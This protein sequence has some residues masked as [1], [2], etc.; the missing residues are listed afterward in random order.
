MKISS[1]FALMLL[2]ASLGCAARPSDSTTDMTCV[3]R[4][5]LPSYPSIA[6][7]ARVEA[8]VSAAVLLSQDGK[9]EKVSM[10][11][12]SGMEYAAKLFY[13]AVEKA[14]KASAFLPSCGGKTVHLAFDFPF[15]TRSE[16]GE[17]VQTVRFKNPNRF[18][19]ALTP[20]PSRWYTVQQ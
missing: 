14:M 18:E 17:T 2:G 4:L 6:D 13:P 16:T 10:G 19:I 3:D 20:A 7:S 15:P 11:P 5:D 9:V 8:G 12:T 1:L